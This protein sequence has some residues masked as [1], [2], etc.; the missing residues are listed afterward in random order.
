MLA[1]LDEPERTREDVDEAGWLA[2]GDLCELDNAGRMRYH[3]RIEDMLRLRGFRV[4]PQEVE[5]AIEG[6]DTVERAQVVGVPRGDGEEV[7][8]AFVKPT[9]DSAVCE[10]ALAAYLNERVADYKVPAR[11]EIVDAFPTTPSP[12]GEKIQRTELAERADD[13]VE[14]SR[15]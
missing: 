5:R 6:H 2:T 9:G 14:A 15:Q 10:D 7:A 11:F 4:A 1:Y 13:L 12:N 8:V 3:S